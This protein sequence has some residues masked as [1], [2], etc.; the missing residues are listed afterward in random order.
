[1]GFLGV[2]AA[3]RCP[4]HPTSAIIGMTIQIRMRNSP[5]TKGLSPAPLENIPEA[6]LFERVCHSPVEKSAAGIG[7]SRIVAGLEKIRAARVGIRRIAVEDV[8]DTH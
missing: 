2:V 4:A 3:G 8:F 5:K 1:M 6:S 7:I